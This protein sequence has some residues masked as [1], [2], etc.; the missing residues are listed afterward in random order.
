MNSS[1]RRLFDFLRDMTKNKDIICP[2]CNIKFSKGNEKCPRCG[3]FSNSRPHCPKC[4]SRFAEGYEKCLRCGWI[5]YSNPRC[6]ACDIE[7]Y[8]SDKK[9]PM[10]GWIPFRNPRCPECNIEFNKGEKKC[11]RCGWF[12]HS[13]SCCSNCGMGYNREDKYCRFCGAK[14]GNPVF[15]PASYSM[16]YG[17]PFTAEHTCAK[18]GFSWEISGLGS[19]NQRYCPECG[20]EAPRKSRR[21]Q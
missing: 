9:C 10:C 12:P 4:E 8:Q 1:K 16:I 3:W 14:N 20:G 17:P 2:E 19:D 6:P 18:C 11:P 7:L 21:G 13:R 5:P 15:I